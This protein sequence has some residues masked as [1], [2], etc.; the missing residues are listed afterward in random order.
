MCAG[1]DEDDCCFIL[2][3]DEKPI[4]FNMAFQAG[5]PV[6]G[7]GMWPVVRFQGLTC[8]QLVKNGFKLV[9]VLLT[10]FCLFQVFSELGCGSY[11]THRHCRPSSL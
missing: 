5:L 6:A 8:N 11:F 3:P 2:I 10:F 4:R 9:Q 1:S 7:K